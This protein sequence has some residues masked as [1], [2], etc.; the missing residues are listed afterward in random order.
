M[1]GKLKIALFI[2][3]ILLISGCNSNKVCSVKIYSPEYLTFNKQHQSFN[4]ASL[5]AL[6]KLIYNEGEEN[7][8]IDQ[9]FFNRSVNGKSVFKK[10]YY[11][12]KDK[13]GYEYIITSV[14]LGN[15]NPVV[16]LETTNPDKNKLLNALREEFTKKGFKVKTMYD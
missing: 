12:T 15:N 11:K 16:T 3:S 7:N 5:N 1:S 9:K 6:T 10:D 13:D 14:T 4:D 2:I 8:S